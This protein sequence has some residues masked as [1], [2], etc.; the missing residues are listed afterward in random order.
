MKLT[1]R[2]KRREDLIS[3]SR[4]LGNGSQKKKTEGKG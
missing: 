3:L 2:L 4:G 1:K